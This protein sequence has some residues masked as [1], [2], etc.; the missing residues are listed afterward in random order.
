[1]RIRGRRPPVAPVATHR[2]NAKITAPEVLLIGADGKSHGPTA[3]EAALAMAE[4]EGLDLVEVAPNAAPP[5][6]RICDNAKLLYE[7]KRKQRE[8][9]KHQR[10]H[11]LKEVKMKP[12]IGPHDYEIKMRHAQE[13][14]EAGHK[15][16]LTVEI[17]G[18][19]RINRE[20]IDGLYEKM[21]AEARTF[22]LVD[23]NTRQIGRSRSVVLSPPREEETTSKNS[24]S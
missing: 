19:R 4:E 15:V 22:A 10:A 9:K 13:F 20:T 6:C 3:R 1:M 7:L 21:V 16:K 14:I 17:R 18:R 8:A 11:D 2:V 5:V 24:K 23:A 12:R